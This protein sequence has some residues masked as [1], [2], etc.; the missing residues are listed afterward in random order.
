MI[1]RRASTSEEKDLTKKRRKGF[2]HD[3]AEVRPARYAG[4]AGQANTKKHKGEQ[5]KGKKDYKETCRKKQSNNVEIVTKRNYRLNRR[6]IRAFSCDGRTNLAGLTSNFA[7]HAGRRDVISAE[8][9]PGDGRLHPAGGGR[10]ISIQGGCRSLQR[11]HS[12]AGD[13]RW[14]G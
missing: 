11:T 2:H 6:D 1:V 5:H 12:P 4:H 13:N 8:I 3:P 7:Q 14:P 9:Q 10:P